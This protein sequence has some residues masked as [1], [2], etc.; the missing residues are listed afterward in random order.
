MKIRW[1][2]ICDYLSYPDKMS[3]QEAYAFLQMSMRALDQYFF[4]S[5]LTGSD[6]REGIVNFRL[7][8]TFPYSR[9]RT[10]GETSEA[11]GRS[12][13]LPKIDMFI[14]R[15]S[16]GVLRHKLDLLH[17]LAHELTHAY[18]ESFFDA[19]YQERDVVSGP[20]NDGHGRLWNSV[21]TDIER[22]IESWHPIFR[23]ISF[24]FHRFDY[25]VRFEDHYLAFLAHAPE[26]RMDYEC[27]DR[28][29]VQ[30]GLL[31]W[32]IRNDGLIYALRRIR[33]P[34][35]IDYIQATSMSADKVFVFAKTLFAVIIIA[36]IDIMVLIHTHQTGWRWILGE[37]VAVGILIKFLQLAAPT[38][39]AEPCDPW[40]PLPSAMAVIFPEM[41]HR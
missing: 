32:P 41:L 8:D 37:C 14:A 16:R 5:S 24:A 39:V 2:F 29:I 38:I 18:V 12:I 34:H 13:D 9:N 22:T 4:S 15:K 19:N 31:R 28:A 17:T 6:N 26:G 7:I 36:L 33:F 20:L 1:G 35:Y 25:P 30:R 40:N 3:Y 10:L 23:G 27:K 11:L 21:N